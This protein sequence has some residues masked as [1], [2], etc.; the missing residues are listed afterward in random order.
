MTNDSL[1]EKLGRIYDRLEEHQLVAKNL[2][3]WIK[4][5]R[6]QVDEILLGLED[7]KEINEG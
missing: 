5:T 4:E 1:T 2:Q 3:I 7:N 6:D